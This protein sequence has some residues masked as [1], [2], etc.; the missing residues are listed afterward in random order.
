MRAL[1][2]PCRQPRACTPPIVLPTPSFSFYYADAAD[3][4]LRAVFAAERAVFSAAE[5]P[6]SPPPMPPRAAARY[7]AATPR[8]FRCRRHCFAA[9][10]FRRRREFAA[11]LLPISPGI[12]P[13]GKALIVSLL[14]AC[15]RL[16]PRHA[17][18]VPPLLPD[19]DARRCRHRRLPPRRA[20]VAPATPAL[21]KISF[22]A[23]RFCAAPIRCCSQF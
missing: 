10:Y 16:T 1:L 17:S 22:I 9:D 15:A 11:R 21:Q 4:P 3:E 14:L 6:P 18:R 19:V 23:R 8:R 2:P 20:A 5:M 7:A 12:I 13:R